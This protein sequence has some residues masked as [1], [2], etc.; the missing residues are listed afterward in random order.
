[1]SCLR[2]PRVDPSRV[3]FEVVGVFGGLGA[4]GATVRCFSLV[5]FDELETAVIG[6]KDSAPAQQLPGECGIFD[7]HFMGGGEGQ[8]GGRQPNESNQKARLALR[9]ANV[10]RL[11]VQCK[12]G[13]T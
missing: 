11:E 2:R 4:F 12:V 7:A 3:E 1:M 9:L 5:R 6:H 13:T 8:A 10:I